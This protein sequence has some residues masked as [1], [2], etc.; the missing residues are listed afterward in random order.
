MTQKILLA[1]LAASIG[2]I[3]N[4]IHNIWSTDSPLAYAD[5]NIPARRAT[6]DQ[7]S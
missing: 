2:G 5:D 4:K 6:S 7:Q 1:K 3:E